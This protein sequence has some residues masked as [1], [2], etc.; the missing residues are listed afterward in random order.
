MD[1][2][3]RV[4]AFAILAAGLWLLCEWT[5]LEK[6]RYY[7][8]EPALW[9]QAKPRQRYYMARYLVDHRLLHGLTRES[10]VEK[11]GKPDRET[12]YFLF[13]LL[14]PERG[15]ISLDAMLLDVAVD[16]TGRVVWAIVR[17]SS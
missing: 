6:Y 16:E 4:C 11:L 13:Y 2:I 1:R 3:K 15:L 9:A 8:F 5:F 7:R 17:V 12:A 14:G 10:V